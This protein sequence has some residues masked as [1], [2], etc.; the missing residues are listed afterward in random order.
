MML[1]IKTLR[2]LW[3]F[4]QEMFLQGKSLQEALRL[5]FFRVL[6]IGLFMLSIAVNFLTVPKAVH[7][8]YDLVELKHRHAGM[9]KQCWPNSDPAL[10]PTGHSTAGAV[11]PAASAPVPAASTLLPDSAA[12][13]F[14]QTELWLR[15]MQQ[16]E[17]STH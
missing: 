8:S 7:L 2:L 17:N 10:A 5:Y 14:R 9:I 4:L 16:R 12:E 1:L 13:Q 6:F 3:P 15:R 11:A